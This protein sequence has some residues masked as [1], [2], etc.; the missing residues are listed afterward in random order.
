MV[1]DL[2][3]GTG[4]DICFLLSKL[5][6]EKGEVIGVDM[7]EEQLAVAHRHVEYHR[8]KFGFRRSN[9]RFLKGYIEDLEGPGHRPRIP[10]DVVVSNCVHQSFARQ[11]AGVLRDLPG[12]EA[13]RRALFF[14]RFHGAPNVSDLSPDDPVLLGE[15]LAGALYTEVSGGCYL[16]CG[17]RD[18]RTVSRVPLTR[19]H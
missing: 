8:E 2:G 19:L 11:A 17:I 6:G 12:A 15:C 1:L 7:T 4:R 5:V 13:R 18:C 16:D 14:G 10:L 3:C 9:V